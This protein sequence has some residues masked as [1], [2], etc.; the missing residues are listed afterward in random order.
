MPFERFNDLV[1]I[2]EGMLEELV[3]EYP[4]APIQKLKNANLKALPIMRNTAIRV[5]LWTLFKFFG[6]DF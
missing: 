5:A 4:D 1:P 3:A 2:V 6:P